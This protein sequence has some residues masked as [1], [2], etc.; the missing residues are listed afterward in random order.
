MWR[1]GRK[2]RGRRLLLPSP[3]PDT[4]RTRTPRGV[5]VATE[6]AA[7]AQGGGRCGRGVGER[8]EEEEGRAGVVEEQG[9]EGAPLIRSR[10]RCESGGW[11]RERSRWMGRR[12]QRA[13]DGFGGSNEPATVLTH[14]CA[15]C[16]RGWHAEAPE[17]L[18][19][20]CGV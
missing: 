15:C 17:A 5:V 2:K 7:M 12:Q 3:W 18:S 14:G 6:G 8:G 9:N 10:E 19:S 16:M 1:R 20:Q 11:V 4:S 13:S